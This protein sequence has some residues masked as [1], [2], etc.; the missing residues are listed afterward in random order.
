MTIFVSILPPVCPKK[1][2]HFENF[3]SEIPTNES[4]ENNHRGGGRNA[5]SFPND[6][7]ESPDD[8]VFQ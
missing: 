2:E 8:H 6:P 5:H 3:N 1:N 7:I 4:S